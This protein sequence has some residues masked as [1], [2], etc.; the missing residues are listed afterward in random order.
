MKSVLN[1]FFF[2]LLVGGSSSLAQPMDPP[3]PPSPIAQFR[4]WLTNSPEALKITLAARSSESRR[5]IE[6]KITEYKAL[7]PEERERRL[8]AT[9][10]QWY[11]S[12]LVNLPKPQRAM[13]LKQI[14]VP[15]QPMVMERLATWDKMS[16]E[17]QQEA[18]A[19]KLVMEY[20]SAPADKK[21]VVLKSLST[22]QSA[23]LR[24]RLARWQFL[25]AVERTRLN[26]RLDDFF[27][28]PPEKQQRTLNNFSD[29]ERKD[30]E[31][32]LESFRTLT[33]EQR[34]VCIRSFAQFAQKFAAMNDAE[35]IA[36]L[37]NAE[38]WQ[39]MSQKDRDMWRQI[40]AIVPPM[41]P[42]PIQLPPVPSPIPPMPTTPKTSVNPQ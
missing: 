39:E 38:R 31:K 4:A 24:Q 20:V 7:L 21:E 35:K 37:K 29:A 34:D 8:T 42:L 22:E 14:P 40:V 15:W 6:R 10:L 36:F 11:V 32:T 1:I 13:G 17:L 9:E 30:M 12:Y 16:P 5:A 26:E 19:H 28:M 2:A 3:M 25:P 23:A 27:N 41:P 18:R 33:R